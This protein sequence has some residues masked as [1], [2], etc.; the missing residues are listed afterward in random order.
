MF[1]GP[2]TAVV[3]ADAQGKEFEFRLKLRVE[4]P[5]ALWHA[6]ARRCGS[7]IDPSID[8]ITDLIGPPED[9]SIADCLMALALPDRLAGC[10]MMYA[11][12]DPEGDA[13]L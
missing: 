4:C 7:S 6:A 1:S 12:L 8:D 3:T 9:P 5:T 10:T 11:F 2:E 13:I